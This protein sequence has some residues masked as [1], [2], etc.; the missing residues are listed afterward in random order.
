MP[1]KSSQTAHS[2]L[3]MRGAV[4]FDL[5]SKISGR[6]YRILVFKPF[7][8]PPSAGYPVVTV[9]D[10][11]LTFPTAAV[12]SG[13]MGMG[14]GAGALVVGVTY[15]TDDP[16]AP[17]KLRTRDL[18]WP[19]PLSRIRP[20]PGQPAPKLEDYGGGP[21]FYRFLTEELRPA[22]AAAWPVD[23]ESQTLYG[24][25]LGGL[26]TLSV[27]FEHPTAFRTF[28]ASSPSIWWNRK[29]LLKGEAAFARRVIAREIEPRVLIT[30]GAEEQAPLAK[31]PPGMTRAQMKRL[32]TA[33]RMVDNARDLA[34]RLLSLK[35]GSGYQVRF[36]AFEQ[37]DHM[38]VVPASLSRALMFALRG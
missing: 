17:G 12:T 7:A 19:T 10:A 20:Q 21:E 26:F 23:P 25:S 22:I 33:A 13:A 9:L 11:A 15:P 16:L 1:K 8:P 4:Q 38:S 27:L 29:A 2:P 24:H 35:G 32:L 30:V 14:G 5:P 3:P 31:P 36:Q 34:E 28:T 18:T 37:E 6:T